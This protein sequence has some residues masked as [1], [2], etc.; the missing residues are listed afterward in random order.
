VNP[1]HIELEIT[2]TTAM[3]NPGLTLTVLKELS[4]RGLS[5]SLDDFGKGYSSLNYLKQ[6]PVNTI[7]IDMSFIRDVLTEP[8]DSA[9]VR[10]IILLAQNLNMKVL[11]E[12]VETQAQ[13]DYLKAEG[14]DL[15]QGYFYS[16]PV[17]AAAFE[18]LLRPLG[19]QGPKA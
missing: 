14:C 7:K 11:A 16:R 18:A 13:A 8:K 4:S 1:A 10:A 15:A 6:F 5:I 3:K 19:W 9:I 12:G 17:T 2:E